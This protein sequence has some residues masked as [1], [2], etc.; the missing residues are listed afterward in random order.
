MSLE[1]PPEGD[2][3]LLLRQE[4][5]EHLE[6][7]GQRLEARVQRQDHFGGFEFFSVFEVASNKL[8]LFRFRQ[9]E[10]SFRAKNKSARL[11]RPVLGVYPWLGDTMGRLNMRPMTHIK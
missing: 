2:G 6:P 4:D 7:E 9:S 11:T 3:D 1:D 8:I 10:T 5:Q